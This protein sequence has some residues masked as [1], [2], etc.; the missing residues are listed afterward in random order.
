MLVVL[1]LDSWDYARYQEYETPTVDSLPEQKELVP[2]KD[3]AAGELITQVLW[4]AMM[5][6]ESPKLLFPEFYEQV[7]GYETSDDV[8]N[9]ASL[10]ERVED[11]GARVLPN[12]VKPAV[13]RVAAKVGLHDPGGIDF[14]KH[15]AGRRLLDRRSSVQTAADSPS[16]VSVPGINEDQ[17]NYELTGMMDRAGKNVSDNVLNVTPETFERRAF[18][19]DGAHLSETL[20]AVNDGHDLVWAHFAGLDF[21][22]HMFADSEAVMRRWYRF[23]DRI[24]D[25]VLAELDEEDTLVACSDHGMEASGLHSHRAFIGSTKP[26][27]GDQEATMEGLRSVLETELEGHTPGDTADDLDMA[28]S[29]ETREHLQD[30]GYID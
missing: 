1:G 14:D 8:D 4:P 17:R 11:I 20:R 24:V 16:L 7:S 29:D 27:W 5:V 12:S 6:G 30:L 18:E 3:L 23:Y 25:L 26:L 2:F 28:M 19:L 13:G 22:Q 21:M 10:T 15:G 9:S